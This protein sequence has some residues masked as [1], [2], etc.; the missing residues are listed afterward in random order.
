MRLVS[1][2]G[3]GFLH[4]KFRLQGKGSIDAWWPLQAGS[5]IDF[6]LRKVTP[7]TKGRTGWEEGQECHVWLYRL[8]T[9]QLQGC[10]CSLRWLWHLKNTD[11][12]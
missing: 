11:L 2:S 1:R 10:Y 7:T 8:G 9:E 3:P 5:V 4:T 12:I 6:Y